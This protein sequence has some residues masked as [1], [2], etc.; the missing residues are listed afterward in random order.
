MTLRLKSGLGAF[1][2][3]AGA[4]GARGARGARG[5]GAGGDD[6]D[7]SAAMNRSFE[8]NTDK[9]RRFARQVKMYSAFEQA[10]EHS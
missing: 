7:S 3:G 1:K 4:V 5:A 2:P 6:G 10:E 9:D 8:P